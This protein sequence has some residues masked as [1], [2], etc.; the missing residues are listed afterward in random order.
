MAKWILPERSE[1]GPTNERPVRSLPRHADDHWMHV[2]WY[3]VP[4][5]DPAFPEVYTY[6]DAMSYAPGDEVR[7][8]SSTTAPHWSLEVYRDGWQPE[9]VHAASDLPGA[10]SAT[11]KDAYK[12]GCGWATRH[13]WRLPPDLRSGFYRVVSTCAR[14]NGG[15]FMQHHCF[16]VRP[17][18]ATR[19]GRL[20]MLLPTA[21]WTAYNDWGGAN[22]YAGID[23][24][25]AN[26]FSPVLSLQRPWVRGTVWLPPGAPRNITEPPPELGAA[27]QYRAQEWAFANGFGL[28]TSCA[29]W[30]QYDR[31]FARWA[32][33]EGYAF[34]MITQTDLQFRPEILQGYRCVVVVGHD[35]YWSGPMRAALEA[36][37]ESGGRLAR[38]GAD[39]VWQIRLED[40]G[41]R[42]VCYKSRAPGEDP[43]RG[44][45]DA[46]LLTTVWE[47]PE[48]GWP[49][50]ATFGVN[51]IEGIYANWGGFLPRGQRGLTV[52]RP[53]HWV[54]DNTDLYY[55]DVFGAAAGIVGYEVDGLDYTFRDGLPYPTGRDGAATDIEILAMTPATLAEGTQHGDGFRMYIRDVD[56]RGVVK[57]MT[58]G[59]A[60][61]DLQRYRHGAAMLVHMAKGKGEVVTGASCEWV[62][63]LTRADPFTQQITRNV[64]NR[65]L[66]E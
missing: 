10:F 23:G 42:Q 63:G 5:D 15:R 20:L 26:Q 24:G 11:P 7:F 59:D 62:M 16:V 54:F 55:G 61:T 48:V 41:R 2:H 45:A 29:G 28:Y 37:T 57:L 4:H 14:A 27:T 52:Y 25:D 34:D 64:L 53:E 36:F 46:R 40:E 30:A 44:T 47:A 60:E 50:A 33:R 12:A 1:H 65:F 31:H 35:E 66:A 3:E 8:H 13:V 17:N 49:G 9:L 39:Y 22:H 6:T 58:G 21:T 32:E 38:F 56:L 19:R 51:G 43:V 18:A